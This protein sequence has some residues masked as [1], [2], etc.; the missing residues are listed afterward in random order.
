MVWSL[1]NMTQNYSISQYVP[2]LFNSSIFY[3][4]ENKEYIPTTCDVDTVFP[5]LNLINDAGLNCY[6]CSHEFYYIM[7]LADHTGYL[8]QVQGLYFIAEY[9]NPD[10]TMS[11]K[12]LKRQ[13]SPS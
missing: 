5:S 4:I 1:L 3:S 11:I 12:T 13:F 10:S 9:G 2:F 7:W 8:L 6:V